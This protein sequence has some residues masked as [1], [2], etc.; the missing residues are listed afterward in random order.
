M[1]YLPL[2]AP[3]FSIALLVHSNVESGF[4]A[5]QNQIL[6][7]HCGIINAHEEG[8]HGC[9]SYFNFGGFGILWRLRHY[10]EALVSSVWGSPA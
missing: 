4:N 10:L 5:R 9:S 2:A 3:T 6:L 1:P 7:H 8:F